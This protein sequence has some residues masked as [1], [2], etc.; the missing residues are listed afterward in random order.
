[1][2]NLLQILF[3]IVALC[4]ELPFLTITKICCFSWELLLNCYVFFIFLKGGKGYARKISFEQIKLID[5]G[6]PIIIDQQYNPNA[7]AAGSPIQISDVTFRDIYGS[8]ADVVAINLNCGDNAACTNI[9]I[10]NVNITS[11]TPGQELK[12]TCHN[13]QGTANSASPAVPC[14][15]S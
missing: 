8:S 6:N 12:A 9:L 14:L 11:G 13:A 3:I 1:M 2:L 10:N 4:T 7:I 5:S 15:S